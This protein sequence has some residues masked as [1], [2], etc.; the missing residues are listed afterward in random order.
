MS[1]IVFGKDLDL[2]QEVLAVGRKVGMTKKLWA[3]LARNERLFRRTV[4][5]IQLDE[6]TTDL[7]VARG[8]MRENFLGPGEIVKHLH[9]KLSQEE[10]KKIAQ[11]PFSQITLFEHMDTHL[12][13]LGIPHDKEGNLLTIYTLGRMFHPEP[14][15]DSYWEKQAWETLSKEAFFTEETCELRWYLIN[16]IGYNTLSHEDEPYRTDPCY[17]RPVL[18]YRDWKNFLEGKEERFGSIE[19]AVVYYYAMVLWH[20]VTD[21]FLFRREYDKIW[22]SSY[23]SGTNLSQSENKEV[24]TRNNVLNSPF[25]RPWWVRG[26]SEDYAGI[27]VAPACK[28]DR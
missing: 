3:K 23:H 8:I 13:V 10:R 25:H 26:R 18:S 19:K 4:S 12:L 21:E 15:P 14:A 27:Y 1:R 16:K 2:L 24:V 22:T 17:A 7:K 28:P 20:Q 5:F 9:V 6:P 11:V